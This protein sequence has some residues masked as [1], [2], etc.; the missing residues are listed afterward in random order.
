[1]QSPFPLASRFK[2]DMSDKA[3]DAL[4]RVHIAPLL[5]LAGMSPDQ[6]EF[7]LEEAWKA[8]VVPSTQMRLVIRKIATAAQ[9]YSEAVYADEKTFLR[10]VYAPPLGGTSNFP[11]CLTGLAG[12][13]KSQI[14]A[15]FS[16]VYSKD[17]SLS[18]PGHTDF[19]I[20]SAW[21]I[22]VRSD[23]GAKRLL[24]SKFRCGDGKCKSLEEATAES[25]KQGIAAICVD[26][27]QFHTASDANAKT[28]K[29][30]L[31]LSSVGPPLVFATN[32]SLLHKLYKRPHEERQRLFSKPILVVP[33]D[34]GS[35]DWGEYVVAALRVAPEFSELAMN[36]IAPEI[37][38]RYTFG[39]R[40][41]VALLLKISY[42]RMRTRKGDKV[43]MGDVESAYNSFEYAS[44]R[45]DVTLL[46]KGSI[47]KS[48]LTKDLYCPIE[49]IEMATAGGVA[50]HPAIQEHERRSGEEAL[51]SSLTR[52][53]REAYESASGSKTRRKG[54]SAP[55]IKR[56]PATA[57]KLINAA[58]RFLKQGIEK[59][60]QP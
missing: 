33:D 49:G 46:V 37:L 54:Q 18:L 53:E 35:K 29:L 23:V 60:P 1:M 10:N 20:S 5:D 3:M 21:H 28:A 58:N 34:P 17:L 38:H 32:F 56:P 8:L 6:A 59:D 22:A 40:R 42:S 50:K 19:S 16:R 11:I 36:S 25:I 57:S 15:G 55:P 44:A 9:Q 30:L 43:S 27:F 24:G 45:E 48:A 51:K 52:E 39:I 41:S 12:I 26:E 47:N 13:G 31:Q 7:R 4:L 2:T 14:I